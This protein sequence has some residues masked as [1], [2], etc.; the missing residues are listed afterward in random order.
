MIAGAALRVARWATSPGGAYDGS[1]ATGLKKI[2]DWTSVDLGLRYAT[3]LG[4]KPVTLR[5]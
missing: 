3:A 2:P 4:G 1:A 5:A